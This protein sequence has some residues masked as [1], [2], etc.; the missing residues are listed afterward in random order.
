MNSDRATAALRRVYEE[1]H[2]AL[3]AI[4]AAFAIY[5]AVF[6]APGLPR[7]HARIETLRAQDIA[8]EQD[9]TCSKLGMS[10]KSP[11]HDRCIF[12]LQ[13]YRARIERRF[14]EESDV[15]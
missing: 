6:V 1:V 11:M 5:F 7:I 8:A 15:F 9:S 10:P 14:A 3:W 2:L 4:L 12:D 13:Q